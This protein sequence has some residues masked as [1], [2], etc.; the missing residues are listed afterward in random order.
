MTTLFHFSD[1]HLSSD[2]NIYKKSDLELSD[3]VKNQINNNNIKIDY[4]IFT[5]DFAYKEHDFNHAEY[6]F[7]E[8]S[9]ILK[10]DR[11]RFL[12]VPG[13]HEIPKDS[14]EKGYTK[15]QIFLERF[16][17][18]KINLI[19]SDKYEDKFKMDDF[20]FDYLINDIILV[21]GFHRENFESIKIKNQI[22]ENTSNK[23]KDKN[24]IKI[25]MLH[26]A[27]LPLIEMD[28]ADMLKNAGYF[29]EKLAENEY[30]IFLTG[31]SHR[32][33]ISL[34]NTDF[35]NISVGSFGITDLEKSFNTIQIDNN[36]ITVKS[37]SAGRHLIEPF[38]LQE[39]RSFEIEKKRNFRNH[40]QKSI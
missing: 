36:I 29:S 27:I 28:D 1:L 38:V 7:E 15:F 5:G 34:I 26:E 40:K 24:L 21:S 3:I 12:F 23:Y 30:K 11:E 4:V 8:L 13:N 6:F 25:A 39:Q 33:K 22:I 17:K 14:N 9:K 35:L 37:Y 16:Y 2:L 18:D 19:Y 31:H 20:S 10:L 32:R